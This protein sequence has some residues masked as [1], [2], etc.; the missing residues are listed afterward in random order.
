VGM[1]NLFDPIAPG[2]YIMATAGVGF[3]AVI[4]LS[5]DFQKKILVTT[6]SE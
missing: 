2:Y 4:F 3:L 6:H 5:R 1:I